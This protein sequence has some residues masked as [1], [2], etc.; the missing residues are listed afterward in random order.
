MKKFKLK[1][2]TVGENVIHPFSLETRAQS[3]AVFRL[4]IDGIIGLAILLIIISALSYFQALRVQAANDK[5][6]SLVES[7]TNSPNGKVFVEKNLLFT[8]GGFNTISIRNKTN[9]FEG[10]F[11][12]QSRLVSAKIIGG[13]GEAST[14]TFANVVETNVYAQCNPEGSGC[15]I[16]DQECCD[17]KCIISFGKK[18]DVPE[19]P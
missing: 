18:L 11:E 7:A 14:V 9:I 6:Y 5:F 12:F 15:P 1:K 8:P 2:R 10:C 19:S 16:D 4:M 13:E 17:M 3:G